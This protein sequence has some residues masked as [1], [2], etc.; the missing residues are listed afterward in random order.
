M[1]TIQLRQNGW[2]AIQVARNDQT[3]LELATMYG[4][5]IP[6]KDGRLISELRPT[7]PS[8]A[9]PNTFASVHGTKAYPLHTDTAF[10]PTPARYIILSATGDLRRSTTLCRWEALLQSF[11][12]A[13]LRCIESSIWTVTVTRQPFLCTL[14]FNSHDDVGYRF[15][16]LAMSPINW[17]AQDARQILE[18]HLAKVEPITFNWA[19]H[20][21]LVLDNWKVLHGRG[22]APERE[23]ERVVSRIYIE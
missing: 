23:G 18:D 14:R 21:V 5:P 22:A 2:A 11:L 20:A 12:I 17:A 13:E 19:D 16:P 1:S 7:L 4:R 6:A 15:D 8:K 3:L 9:A 10:W